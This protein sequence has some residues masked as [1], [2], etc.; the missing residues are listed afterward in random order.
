SK[1]IVT[2]SLADLGVEAPTGW[3][4]KVLAAEPPPA[5]GATQIVRGSAA[6]GAR[7]IADLL[8]SRGLL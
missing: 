1:E 5:R 4:T 2:H 3:S 8:A 6:D 7:A